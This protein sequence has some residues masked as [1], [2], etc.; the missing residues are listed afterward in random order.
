[1]TKKELGLP[2]Y[3][4]ATERQ[5]RDRMCWHSEGELYNDG[6]AF[7]ACARDE[8]GIIV[9]VIADN[10]FGYC[11]KEV[12]TQIGYSANLSGQVEE[13]HSGGALAF[14]SYDLGREF[15]DRF[16]SA[17]A[18]VAAVVARD[19]EVFE[20]R[21]EGHAVHREHPFVVV[22]ARATY[23]LRSMTVSWDGPLG[24]GEIPLR[25][26]RTYFGPDGYRVAMAQHPD[27]RTQW[28][29]VG[30]SPVVTGF[31]KP[32]TVSGGGKSEISKAI[33]DSIGY[34][35][36]YVSDFREDMA[37]VE[38]ILAYDLPNRFADPERCGTDTRSVL[39]QDRSVGS[40]IKLLTPSNEY[41]DEYNAW[42][43]T[44][45]SHVK[46]LLYVIKSAYR[47]EWGDDWK[48]HF[49]VG[50]INGRQGNVL[51]LDGNR[52]RVNT[53][54]V[55]FDKDGSWRVFGLRPDFSPAVKVQTEDDIT[56][57]IV[58]SPE[59]AAAA[60][61]TRGLSAKIVENC[62]MLLFQRP[63]DAIHRGYDKQAELDISAPGTFLSNFE[64]LDR[65]TAVAMR[66]DAVNFS[67]F[68]APVQNLIQR[69]ASAA[70]ESASHG[71]G[72][73]HGN[74]HGNGHGHGNGLG[75]GNGHGVSAQAPEGV[76]SVSADDPE[77]FVCSANPRLV[78]G[79]PTKNPRYLQVRPDLARPVETA[80]AELALHLRNRA[81]VTRTIPHVVDIVA[82]GRRNNPPED[83]VPALCAFNPLHYMELPE[84][85][86][87]FISS[88][89]G[90]SPSTTGAGSEG[91]LTKAP[92]NAMPT[93]F[94][95]NSALLSYVLTGYDG[96]ISSAGYIGPQVRVDHDISLLIPEVFSR[97]KPQERD[98]ATLVAEGSLERIEDLEVDGRVVA[99]SRLGYRITERFAPATSD[100]S[101]C[102]P[103]SCSPRTCCDP[104]SRIWASS[105]TPSTRWSRPTGGWRAATSTTARPTSRCR[106]CGRCWR[107][108]RTGRAPPASPWTRQ[109]CGR[110]STGRTCWPATG[111]RP[112]STPGRARRSR[113]WRRACAR[114]P[115]SSRPPATRRSSRASASTSGSIAC[116]RSSPGS[117]PTGIG[118]RSSAPSAGRFDSV[119]AQ[120]VSLPDAL[121]REPGQ[122]RFPDRYG[123]PY[124]SG[125][126]NAFSASSTGR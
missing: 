96:W 29:L 14:P 12:K 7:K 59:T 52:V 31:H 22:P 35:T 53:L 65:S 19:P 105:S 76:E 90:K 10:Y 62:E 116:A 40:V 55:G 74:G 20:R 89:T 18:S 11:K 86:M 57:S 79:K 75:H 34:G 28:T 113:T 85:F 94:D 25:A 110:C 118:A 67:R 102:T 107:S 33:T 9:T 88:M 109:S 115:T 97:M 121:L 48:R 30:T 108:W 49:S 82:A 120:R 1:M 6:Q 91:A 15:L 123:R 46:E 60:G 23:S 41:T 101:S 32:S 38:S 13:E 69:A 26:D 104:S 58:V 80:A 77:Y 93:T 3:D 17:E 92:F 2:H 122:A 84:L 45:P 98:A 63:D 72:F 112:G 8:R 106:R 16:G 5:R 100:A 83:G 119:R 24:R 73:D 64:P 61:S 71:H 51:R 44:I 117:P 70:P 37:A 126:A 21:P 111:T 114:C 124:R 66:D 4:H 95:L 56:A 81:S 125:R 103:R 99:A 78:G 27:D 36:A 68:T 47:P 39:G 42:L 50:I 54:R 87:E 43:E